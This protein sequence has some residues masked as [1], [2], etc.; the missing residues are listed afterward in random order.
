MVSLWAIKVAVAH[1][2]RG[3]VNMQQVKLR[4]DTY[5]G[6]V[7]LDGR[8]GSLLYIEKSPAYIYQG[9]TYLWGPGEFATSVM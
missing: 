4:S 2:L 7:N 5:L 3:G 1:Q 6:R 8:G 9:I